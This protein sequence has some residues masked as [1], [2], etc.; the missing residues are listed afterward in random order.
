MA[1]QQRT[2]DAR[3]VASTGRR[4]SSRGFKP[5]SQRGSA[6]S[7]TMR[8]T[9]T[10]MERDVDNTVITINRRQL[11]QSSVGRNTKRLTNTFQIE[12]T[13]TTRRT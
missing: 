5:P 2:D 6:S 13:P 4:T 11:N 8:K 1:Q 7:L 10:A 12:S 9:K 3:K